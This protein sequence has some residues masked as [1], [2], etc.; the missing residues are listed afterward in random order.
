MTALTQSVGRAAAID[1]RLKIAIV[2]LCI[3]GIGAPA[4][5]PTSTTR[6]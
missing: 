2:I 1:R 4:I 3:L 6:A 5:S